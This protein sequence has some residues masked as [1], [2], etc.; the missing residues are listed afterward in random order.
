MIPFI[1]RLLRLNWLWKFLFG[2]W[3]VKR[4]WGEDAAK[5]RT[6]KRSRDH[7]ER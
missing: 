5:R 4:V 2:D 7:N 6:S 1:W 3:L